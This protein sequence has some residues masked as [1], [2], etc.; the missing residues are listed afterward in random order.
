LLK[1]AALSAALA[2][3]AVAAFLVLQGEPGAF[4]KK[5]DAE[6]AEAAAAQA[7][8]AAA[9]A[10]A[11]A[12]LASLG[13]AQGRGGSPHGAHGSVS[14]SAIAALPMTAPVLTVDGVTFARAD[15]ERTIA[16]H[17]V[18]A[19]IPP[20]S[21]D[22][23]TRDALEAPAYEKLIERE[24]LSSEARRRGLWPTP[25][26]V[27]GEKAKLT[28]SLPPGK[29]LAEA[30]AAMGSDETSFV[31][32]LTSDVAIGRLFE[33]MKK[34]HGAPD[35]ARLKA[36]YEEH[37]DKFKVPDTA[38]AS[39]ILVRL[40]QDADPEAVK[41]AL[42]KAKAIR[43]EVANKDLETFKKVAT[44]K[45]EDP[46]AKVNG[47]DLGMFTRGEMVPAF[48]ETA[49]K[50]KDGELSQPVRSD[51]GFHII[52]GG[53]VKPGSQKSFEEVKGMIAEREGM[54]GF[55][56]SVDKLIDELRKS[57]RITR[58]QEPMPSPFSPDDGKGTRVPAW[59]PG[60]RN[61][62]PNRPNPHGPG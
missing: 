41:A 62:A 40:A 39:H 14:R 10:E 52:R 59:K 11:N 34:E 61:A 57:A 32:D 53:G 21:L 16:Q 4:Q 60:G 54:R 8:A 9:R 50:L 31:T 27:D 47:G 23:Q 45:S 15:L 43:A 38:Q 55:M 35:D 7:R 1:I 49:F 30:L 2:A 20:L 24:L 33:A 18:V 36:V 22:A 56:E 51:F 28:A 48:D 42:A 26:E 19:G 12:G 17:A 5:K 37:K 29:S 44:E 25:A 3:A 6:A 58:L 13:V 46:S